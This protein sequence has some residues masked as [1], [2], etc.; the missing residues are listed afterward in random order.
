MQGPFSAWSFAEPAARLAR[1]LEARRADAATC[2]A[3]MATTPHGLIVKAEVNV[4]TDR[5]IAA[6][7]RPFPEVFAGF[8]AFL[9]A[10]RAEEPGAL[11]AGLEIVSRI[12]PQELI[13]I[14]EPLLEGK[15]WN[16][17]GHRI[18]AALARVD[19]VRAIDLVLAHED[20]P[21]VRMGIKGSVCAAAQEV[22][23]ARLERSVALA[24]PW[25]PCDDR[26]E[27]MLVED[28]LAYLGRH[29]VE[30]AWSLV[31]RLYELHPDGYVRLGAG[32]AL[33][34]WGDERSLDLL[35]R[36]ITDDVHRR[37]FFAVRALHRR[38]GVGI[39][40]VLGET[41]RADVRL[42][43]EVLH[44]IAELAPREE[45][46]TDEALLALALHWV[47][48]RQVKDDAQW[49]L[50]RFPRDAVKEAK[51][52]LNKQKK[53]GSRPKKP[54][55]AEI[56]AVRRVVERARSTLE[57]LVEGLRAIGYRFEHEPPLPPREDRTKLLDE[58]ERALEGS[59][60]VS[61]RIALEILGGTNLMGTF[62]G[63]PRDLETDPFVLIHPKVALDQALDEGGR[64]AQVSL[65]IA[66]DAIGKAGFSGGQEVV[67]V[68]S[69]ALDAPVL[70]VPGEPLFLDRLSELLR[71][72]G[73]ARLTGLDAK[74]RE[75][76]LALAAGHDR[77]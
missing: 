42:A 45:P 30:R 64:E 77:A 3:T 65:A 29:R 13:P 72:S 10:V 61:L 73:F 7:S 22:V 19:D 51:A 49:V 69:P 74:M 59:L 58:V 14:V 31:A 50:D 2:A 46:F 53:P 21:Y 36:F 15:P 9:D 16:E 39:V 62:P 5:T 47:G 1:V 71:S 35:A 57:R 20:V 67:L 25:T 4:Y 24:E 32:H 43:Q 56:A 37:L 18:G 17:M 12:A 48:D 41:V 63:H 75:S 68:P 34:E 26:R 27:T 38:H 33:L 70:G 40:T 23:R 8:E 55:K 6:R 60:P 76:V 52:R 28:I 11:E 54:T 44:Q 66:P